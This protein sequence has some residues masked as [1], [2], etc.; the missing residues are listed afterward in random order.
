[1]FWSSTS[2]SVAEKTRG[3]D[4]AVMSVSGAVGLFELIR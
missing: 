3:T 4:A 2:S 1:V